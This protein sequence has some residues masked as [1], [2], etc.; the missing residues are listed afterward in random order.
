M[1]IAAFP[2]QFLASGWHIQAKTGY[3]QMIS[4]QR[5]LSIAW[6]VFFR[7]KAFLI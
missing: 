1:G 3:E 4:S 5:H 2:P 7:P 6:L